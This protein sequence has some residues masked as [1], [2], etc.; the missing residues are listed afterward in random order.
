MAN[1]LRAPFYYFGGKS[2][3]ASQVWEA[4]G[5]PDH[6]IEP[7]CGSAAVLLARPDKDRLETI[8]DADGMVANFWRAARLKPEEV[9]HHLDYP[10]SE[11]DLHSRHQWLIDNREKV[12]EKLLADPEWCD[13]K[14]AGWWCWGQ[15]SWIGDGWM[16]R[17]SRQIPSL[18]DLGRGIV[19]RDPEGQIEHI[20]ALSRRLSR[21]RICCGDW[22]RVC[23]SRTTLFPT[24]H[25]LHG[26]SITGIFLDPPYVSGNQQYAMGGTGTNISALVGDW[27]IENGTNP[28]L[29]IVLAGLPEEHSEIEKHGWSLHHWKAK[30][31]YANQSE[32][33]PGEGGRLESLWFSPHCVHNQ[34]NVLDM[35]VL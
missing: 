15:N 4:L 30:G 18:S 7:F 25:A 6:Y 22:K 5:N 3:A 1:H 16:S 23:G 20:V 2:R 28:R 21:V 26:N 11:V 35:F 8:N 24:D 29:R 19:G 14:V 27:C 10:I 9:A 33:A 32:H 17:P 34:S 13:A 31:G 12:V